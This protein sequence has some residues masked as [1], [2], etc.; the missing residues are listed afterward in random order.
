LLPHSHIFGALLVYLWTKSNLD[1]LFFLLGAIFPDFDYIK[2]TK[3]PILNASFWIKEKTLAI[4]FFPFAII[5]RKNIFSLI[6]HRKIMHSLP[7]I[8]Y[9][10]LFLPKKEAFI[11]GAVVHLILDSLTFKGINYLFPFANYRISGGI[12]TGKIYRSLSIWGI[13][14]FIFPFALLVLPL[15]ENGIIVFFLVAILYSQISK[16]IS[17]IG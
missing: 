1:V 15:K 2:K 4:F 11:A 10:S 9:V 8:L 17:P 6:G 13:E 5:T 3:N 7:G 16:K 12:A 14:E